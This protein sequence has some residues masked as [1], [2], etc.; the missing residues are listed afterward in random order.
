M[1]LGLMPAPKVDWQDKGVKKVLTLMVPAVFGV[2]VSQINLLLDT[3]LA[4]FLPTGS[5]SW[6][7]YSDRLA[8]LPLG[9]FGIAVATVILPGLSRQHAGDDPEKFAATLDWAIRMILLVAIPAAIAL[10][11]LAEPILMTLFMY[12]KTTA[13]DILM[14]S[15]SLR[16]YALGLLAFMLIKVLAPGYFARQDMKTPVRIGIVAMVAN[17]VLNLIFVWI[18]YTQFNMGHVGLALATAGSAFLNAGLLYRGLRR[19]KV[20]RPAADWLRFGV[21]LLLANVAMAALLWWWMTQLGDWAAWDWLQ[22]AG[23]LGALCGSGLM[24]YLLML[25]FTGLDFKKMLARA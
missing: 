11:I 4:S 16:A 5:V 2:S 14:S 17:M 24:V 12:G 10:I 13:N 18:F 7:Y 8:E 9:V 23:V 1:R 21:Q 22:R 20:L 6:L 25:L 3:V 15:W 19:E